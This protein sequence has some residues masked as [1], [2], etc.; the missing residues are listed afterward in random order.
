MDSI[1]ESP[2]P[3]AV[4]RLSWRSLQS[5]D[6]ETI[7][8]L[9]SICLLSD[10]GYPMGLSTIDRPDTYVREHYLPARPGASIGAFGKDGELSAV[11]AIRPTHTSEEYRTTIEGYVHPDLRRLG[12]GDYLLRWSI[13]EA[14]KLF[15]TCPPD[16]PHI[17]QISTESLTDT[18][19]RL[20]ERHDFTQRF[21]ED[22]MRCDLDAHLTEVVPPPGIR[23]A[24][25]EPALTSQF[26][27]VYQEAFRMR[28]AYPNWS[29]KEWMA[30]MV[31]DEDFRPEFSVL[32]CK[33]D[34]PVGFVV[35]DDE[36]MNQ[37]GVRP[38]WCGRG[39]GSALVNEV[40]KRFQAAGSAY[41][42]TSV[43]A[44]NP[45]AARVYARSGFKQVGRRARYVRVLR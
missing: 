4:P 18:A 10:G 9:A 6:V 17:L 7:V 29:Q 28:P 8:S 5:A 13:V 27:S 45:R 3:P 34:R 37:I 33:D 38:E 16:P 24:T 39:V 31:E 43:N 20:Y 30:C 12:I 40:L 2:T 36:W 19:A 1:D 41:A 25:W 42:M 26:F 15:A 35:C 22:V 21:A 14:R 23:F 11:A 32:A 44:N